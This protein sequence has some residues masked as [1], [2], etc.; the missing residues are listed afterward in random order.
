MKQIRKIS[1]NNENN[2]VIFN[3]TFVSFFS[4]LRFGVKSAEAISKFCANNI[5]FNFLKL[6]NLL[7]DDKVASVLIKGF[8][9]CPNILG[10]DLSNNELTETTIISLSKKRYNL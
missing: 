8:K 9:S 6:S 5:Y 2:N 10:I 4:I 7:I 3:L 1:K